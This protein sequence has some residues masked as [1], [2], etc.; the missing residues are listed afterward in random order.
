MLAVAAADVLAANDTGVY[1]KPGPRQYPGQWNWDAAFVVIGLAHLD[2]TRARQE[3]RALLSGQWA[4]GMV[5]HIVFHDAEPQYFPGPEAWGR[6]SGMPATATTGITQPPLLATAVERLDRL[7][8]DP[9]FLA[10]VVPAIEQWHR[11]FH[12]HRRRTDGL[13]AILHPWESGMDNS[14]RFDAALAGVPTAAA[15]FRRED[16]TH[17]AEDQRP[18]DRDYAA[19]ISILEQLRAGGYRSEMDGATFQVGDVFLTAVLAKAERDLALL[20]NKVGRDGSRALGRAQALERALLAAWETKMGFFRDGGIDSPH[21]IGGLLPL[22]ALPR[23]PGMAK[24]A[25]ALDDPA[26]Y[27]PAANAPWYPTGIP[28]NSLEF[29]RRRYWRGP[30][31]VNINWL[32]A[33]TLEQ[34][35]KL[36]AARRLR[37]TTV[38]MV[39]QNGF[40]EYYDPFTGQGLGSESFSWTAALVVDLLATA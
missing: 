39:A 19:Y 4:D 12:L 36:E 23:H 1:V 40:W 15:S 18:T 27:G 8:P 5:P 22:F 17:V 28:K 24:L 3:V 16:R 30:V 33:E 2:P 7:S 21:T 29:D 20:W 9:A 31:W 13:V 6:T 14:P 25:D 10:E 38:D 11:W 35:G 37:V 34:G 26:T 32:L